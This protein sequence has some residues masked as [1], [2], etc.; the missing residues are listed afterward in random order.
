MRDVYE[1][2]KEHGVPYE[3]YEHVAVFTTDEAEKAW[4]GFSGK[5]VKNLFLTNRKGDK[6]Y[7][8]SIAHDKRADLKKLGEQLCEKRLQ[9]VSPEGLMRYL[10]LTPGSVSPLGLINDEKREVTFLLDE[11]LLNQ[12]TIYIHPNINT[13]T[14]VVAWPDF[15][16]FLAACG[17]PV[18]YVSV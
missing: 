3:K 16:R 5:K 12:D 6:Y 10:G 13:A 4:T 14:I 1:V 8:V 17:N 18:Q 11:E 7:L 2:L 9:F 15:L